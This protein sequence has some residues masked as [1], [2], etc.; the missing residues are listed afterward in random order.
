VR[1]GAARRDRPGQA[2]E[3]TPICRRAAAGPHLL[4]VHPAAAPRAT[5]ALPRGPA[6][7]R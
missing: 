4:D 6:L 3:S 1:S 2:S 7:L 5:R